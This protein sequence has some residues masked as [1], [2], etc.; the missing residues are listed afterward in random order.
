MLRDLLVGAVIFAIA[1][2]STPAQ[3]NLPHPISKPGLVLEYDRAITTLQRGIALNWS[4]PEL[5]LHAFDRM[6]RVGTE[7][8]PLAGEYDVV[9]RQ[10]AAQLSSFPQLPTVWDEQPP[11]RVRQMQRVQSALQSLSLAREV[12]L[13]VSEPPTASP[14]HSS[15]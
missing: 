7:G 4:D 11:V 5:Y 10:L 3:V 6:S 14:S 12:L 1:A 8:D 2:G 15:K 9:R 13:A